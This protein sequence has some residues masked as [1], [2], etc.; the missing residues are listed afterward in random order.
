MTVYI[1][2]CGM[3]WGD[4]YWLWKS[5]SEYFVGNECDL[6]LD[7]GLVIILVKGYQTVHLKCVHFIVCN[8]TL[9]I[10]SLKGGLKEEKNKHCPEDLK[11]I[12][13]IVITRW[14]DICLV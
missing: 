9:V 6:Y 4:G 8:Y 10:L 2:I 11:G 13:I 7:Y 3:G 12:G 14:Y 1:D 5:T